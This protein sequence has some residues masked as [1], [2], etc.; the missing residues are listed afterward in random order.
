[1]PMQNRNEA[2]ALALPDDNV[3]VRRARNGHGLFAARAYRAGQTILRIRGRVV[4]W[5]L[6]WKIG[7]EFQANCYRFGPETYLDPGDGAG[8]WVNHSCAP[9]TAIR[10]RRNQLFLV[11]AAPIRSGAELTFD[12]STT[13][14]DD[15]V[16]T[17]R[18]NCG[19]RS[20]RKR[21]RNFGALPARVR[22]DYL[23]RG[24]VPGFILATLARP[25]D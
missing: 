9:N 10:K 7:G 4:H 13:I 25:V 8:R 20:C 15:D 5:K 11:A 2:G 17:M 16:W 18:C 12:Y 14:G 21:V 22:E 6:L 3:A 24:M 23:A 19:R 1:M